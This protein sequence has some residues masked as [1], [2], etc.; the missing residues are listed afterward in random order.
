MVK[1]ATEADNGPQVVQTI[2]GM[3]TK[4][5]SVS[6][7]GINNLFQLYKGHNF[8]SMM[9]LRYQENYMYSSI[10][11]HDQLSSPCLQVVVHD[12]ICSLFSKIQKLLLCFHTLYRVI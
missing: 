8:L 4:C 2:S 6:L 9:Q 10:R 5:Y 1:L 12:S 11:L 7:F 3:Y